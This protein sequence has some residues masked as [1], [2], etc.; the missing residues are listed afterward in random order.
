MRSILALAALLLAALPARGQDFETGFDAAGR[1]DF[2]AAL[3]EWIPLAA[4]GHAEAGHQI[5]V[6]G[7]MH[8]NGIGVARD[9]AEAARLY[10]LAAAAGDAEAQF[11]LGAMH[12]RGGVVA[13][14][15]AETARLY[16]LAADQG[17]AE[18][19]YGLGLLYANGRG[20]ARDEGEA[21]AW[22]RLAA[23]QGHY[24]ALRWLRRAAALGHVEA[25]FSLGEK[26]E[27]GEG[28]ARDLRPAADWY[29]LAAEQGTAG[30]QAALGILYRDGRGVPRD[31]VRAHMWLSLAAGQSSGEVARNRDLVA[32]SRTDAE[33]SEAERLAREWL[34]SRQ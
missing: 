14:D 7:F 27:G 26:Y 20:V 4:A 13:R 32:G 17:H 21:T 9:A 8:E 34:D 6:L 28:V 1:G 12:E 2:A 10:R 11:N 5:G 19:Q 29:R 22:H 33:I 3:D 15:K 16:R 18:A 24:K 25:Q 30:A 23:A 31:Q